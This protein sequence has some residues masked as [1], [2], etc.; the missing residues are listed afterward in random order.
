MRTE[1]LLKLSN[2]EL[3]RLATDAYEYWE[4]L[5]SIQKVKALIEKEEAEANA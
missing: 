4:K 5:R 2:E 3:D 1:E